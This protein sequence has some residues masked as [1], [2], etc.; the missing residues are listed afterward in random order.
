M[1]R[2]PL[3]WMVGAG[4]LLAGCARQLA[5]GPAPQPAPHIA[6]ARVTPMAAVRPGPVAS[7]QTVDRVVV[8]KVARMLL[9]YAR[10]QV[11]GRVDDIQLGGAP[12]GPKHFQ[13]DKRTPEGH[14]TL[15]YGNPASAYHLSLHISY[16]DARDADYARSMGRAPGGDV[17]IHGQPGG[18]TGRVPGD[19]TD[20]CIALSNAQIEM[21]WAR[22]ADGTP[23]DIEP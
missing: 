1:P 17:F 19:W 9:L 6:A 23:I 20:G 7:D 21:L 8:H 14:Y 13:G 12:T 18:W 11:V 2:L 3:L 4:L 16:P 22:V 10:G 15:D 5:P